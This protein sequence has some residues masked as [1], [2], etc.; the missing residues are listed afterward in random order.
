MS[1]HLNGTLLLAGL[2]WATGEP[3]GRQQLSQS[4]TRQ[5]PGNPKNQLSGA[6]GKKCLNSE[7]APCLFASLTDLKQPLQ[8]VRPESTSCLEMTRLLSLVWI[9]I[10]WWWWS[11]SF[12]VSM[13]EK[14]TVWKPDAYSWKSFFQ[15]LS[16]SLSLKPPTLKGTWSSRNTYMPASVCSPA[17]NICYFMLLCK[18]LDVCVSCRRMLI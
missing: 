6:F 17:V 10:W 4:L 2:P 3:L 12:R 11:S 13:L 18:G 15:V 7:C 5:G 1:A 16:F 8:D 14:C 9:G